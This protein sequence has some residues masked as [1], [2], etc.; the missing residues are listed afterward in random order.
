MKN[1]LGEGEK[2]VLK[3]SKPE[4][5]IK[6]SKDGKLNEFVLHTIKIIFLFL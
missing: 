1:H 6:I 2:S 4:I 3:E 5:R